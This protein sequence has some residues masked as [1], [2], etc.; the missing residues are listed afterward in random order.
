LVQ[1]KYEWL[2]GSWWWPGRR[3][4]HLNRLAAVCKRQMDQRQHPLGTD[5]R[6]GVVGGHN[7]ERIEGPLCQSLNN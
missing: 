1:P 3:D 2:P 7:G 6:L 5:F 4:M